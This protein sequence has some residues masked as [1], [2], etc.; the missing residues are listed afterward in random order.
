MAFFNSK[1]R[2]ALCAAMDLAMQ[3]P[4]QACQSREIAQ[5]Q[6]IPGPYLDQILAA[7]K[8]A[9]IVRS[10]RGAGGGYSLAR[11]AERIR[12]GDIVRALVRGDGLFAGRPVGPRPDA[13]TTSVR[14]IVSEFESRI[15][16]LLTEQLDAVTLAD[17]VRRKQDLDESLS[18]MPGI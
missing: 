3:P 12:V 18:I 2:Y 16:S 4:N 7:L 10:I 8:G 5:R 9:G 15:E 14:W 1:L 17:L 11:P 13:T 6:Q